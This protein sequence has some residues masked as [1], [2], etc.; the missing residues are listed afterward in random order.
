MR[1]IGRQEQ[2]IGRRSDISVVRSKI[3]VVVEIYRSSGTK[4]RSS[5]RYIGRQKQYIG[6][7]SDISVVRSKI[8]TVS[9][10]YRSILKY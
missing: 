10:K 1:Y 2:N 8:S 4:Y 5:F 9:Q 7:R 6:H 3:S